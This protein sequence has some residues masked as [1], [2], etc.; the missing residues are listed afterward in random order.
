MPRA[1]CAILVF[2]RVMAI[3]IALFPVI[4]VAQDAT[5]DQLFQS[6]IEAQQHGDY[7]EAISDY[8]KVL[9][10]RPGDVQAKVNLGA[11]LAHV[12]Q[13]DEAIAT[14]RSA[15]PSVKDKNPILL[16]LALAY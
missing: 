5:P 11:A 16:N 3:L 9:E 10:L 8:R 6:G 14:Y 1:C 7:A 12:G 4:L 13:F 15:L 2:M